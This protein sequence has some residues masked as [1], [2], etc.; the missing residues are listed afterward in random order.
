MRIIFL[1]SS[2]NFGGASRGTVEMAHAV[3][4][5]GHEVL[6]VS[7]WGSCK[8]FV[9]KVNELQLDL[10]VL[11]PRE[12]AFILGAESKMGQLKNYADYFFTQQKYRKKFAAIA[13]KF[14]PDYVQVCALKSLNILDKNAGYQID[15]FARGW[16]NSQFLTPLFRKK[17]KEYRPRFIAIS[18]ATRQALYTGGYAEMKDIYVCYDVVPKSIFDT[19]TPEDRRVF[20]PKNP[21]RILH[22]GGFT[23]EKGQLVSLQIA[24]K[25]KEEKIAFHLNLLGYVYQGGASQKFYE[26]L[27]RLTEEKDL[28]NEVAIL[29]GAKDV[30]SF[31]KATDVLIHPSYTEGLGRV[32]LEAAT[33]AKPVIA[34]AVG[35]VTDIVIH[36]FT[37]FLTDFN[38]VNQYVDYI[39]TYYENPDL[40]RQHGKTGRQMVAANFLDI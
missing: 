23:E 9:D 18:Q 28:K 8:E 13:H 29:V 34:N 35:G 19:Y 16:F 20:S 26:K 22:S 25:L 40:L 3:R 11:D 30:W 17:L 12:E 5:L 2:P 38:V 6:V 31:F 15:F 4:Q 39:K 21:I 32:I 33:F 1:E 36:N 10:E 37:G 7:F 24:E 27:L 14:K